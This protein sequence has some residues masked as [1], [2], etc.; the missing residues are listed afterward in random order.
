MRDSGAIEQDADIVGLL[1]SDAAQTGDVHEVNLVVAKHRNGPCGKIQLVF[2]R[3]W[4]RFDS[5]AQK[6]DC[7]P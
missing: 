4:T 1:H 6:Q 3:R 2:H 5:A 7:R